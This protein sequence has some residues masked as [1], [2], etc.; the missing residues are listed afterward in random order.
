MAFEEYY[1]DETSYNYG[2]YDY[3][4]ETDYYSQ[5]VIDPSYYQSDVAPTPYVPVYDTP[6]DNTP[7][8]QQAGD[9]AATA[10]R[11]LVDYAKANPKD[12]LGMGLG[13]GMGLYGLL[14]GPDETPRPNMGGVDQANALMMQQLAST[15]GLNAD[16]VAKLRGQIGGDYGDYA[17]AA[18]A[19]QAA[20]AKVQ[21]MMAAGPDFTLLPEEESQIAQL[22]QK[23]SSKGMLG[24][25]MHNAE[26]QALKSGFTNNA[27]QRYQSQLKAL[28]DVSNAQSNQTS[29]QFANTG[30]VVNQGESR[31]LQ[32]L[33]QLA[34]TGL[35]GAQLQSQTDQANAKLQGDRSNQLLKVGG[36]IFGRSFSDP[37]GDVTKAITAAKKHQGYSGAA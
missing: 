27:L 35:Q 8:Y 23:W 18:A 7:W 20:T 26:L 6:V 22:A 13:A 14:S 37:A 9:Y 1:P 28:Q 11:G 5:P 29:T 34:Q 16:A 36:D 33:G 24:S 2:Y 32:G 21:E 31:Q 15:R 4:P 19:R 17:D 12:V 25:S 3:Q 10:G 30:N